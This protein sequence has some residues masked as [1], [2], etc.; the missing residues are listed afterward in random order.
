MTPALKSFADAYAL[1]AAVEPA[2]LRRRR[3]T[4]MNTVLTRGLPTV[5]DESWHYT[6]LRP[7]AERPFAPATP[8]LLVPQFTTLSWFSHTPWP[9]IPTFNALPRL[10]LATP[11]PR[12]LRASTIAQIAASE[13]QEISTELSAPS[14]AEEDRWAELN[15]AL[16][17][18]G[19]H[20]EIR[21][22][23]ASPIV[24]L[25]VI[26][27][28]EEAA[29]CHPRVNVRLAAGARA[30]LIEHFVAA[31]PG[32]IICNSV[33]DIRLGR[34]AACEHLLLIGTHDAASHFART[35]VEQ[36]ASS[37]CKQHTVVLGA[38][39]ARMDLAVR[40][41]GRNSE[42]EGNFVA[43]AKG[44]RH[45]DYRAIVCHA[46]AATRSRQILRAVAGRRGRIVQ[47]SKVVVKEN[48]PDSDSSQ[49]C[50][51]ILLAPDAEI[52]TRPQLEIY[53][54][55]VKCAHG[56]TTGKLDANMLFYLLS[57]GIER[58]TAEALLVAAFLRDALASLGVAEVRQEIESRLIAEL[59][60]TGTGEEPR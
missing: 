18:D 3:E 42:F 36:S 6:N 24:V 31:L 27:A 30:T 11:L 9:V 45:V 38:G 41:T 16:F 19:L 58:Q 47:N 35:E 5:A 22:T 48:C 4:A 40:L 32:R 55:A 1:R 50:R 26:G 15:V 60:T 44:G 21:E 33:A 56:A 25:H 10:D 12:G 39:L 54:D 28:E 57:R 13:P 43:H 14:E 59:P 51:G 17:D 20:L 7:L 8:A 29:V 53:T 49:S 2:M 23:M 52:D 37:N 46:A 34:D